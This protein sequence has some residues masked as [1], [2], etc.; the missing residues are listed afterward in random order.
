MGFGNLSNRPTTCTTNAL[1]TG[2][3]VG[4]FAIDQGS[5]GTLYRCSSTNTWTVH[6][7]PYAYPH[8]LVTSGGGSS[9]PPSAPTNLTVQ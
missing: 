7:R 4:Y 9:V 6:Y 3:G 5:Q 2:G 8:P 1:E